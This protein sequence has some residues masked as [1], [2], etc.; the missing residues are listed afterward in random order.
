[1]KAFVTGANG[2]LGHH[3]VSKLLQLNFEVSVLIRKSSDLNELT[4]VDPEQKIKKIYGDL[5][6]VSRLKSACAGQDYIFHLAGLIAYTKKDRPALEK[7]NVEGTRNL[8]IACRGAPGLKRFIYLSSVVAVGASYSASEILNEDSAYT[9]G[10]LNL[11]YF[12]TKRKAELLVLEAVKNA[13]LPGIIFNPSTIYGAGDAKKG[14]RKTQVKVAQ[15]KFP[16]YTS[17]AVNVVSVHD[18][19]DAIVK[20]LEKAR[21]G[22]RY[23]LAGDNITIKKL[24]E[25]IAK[26]AKVSPPKYLLPRPLMIGLGNFFDLASVF[27]FKAPISL[28]NAYTATLYHWF[29]SSKA[30]KELGFTPRSAEQSVTESVAWMKLKKMI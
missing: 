23:I 14:S 28:E 18:V 19:V 11:G 29:D 10:N 9:I 1:M 16:F 26:M 22:Q 17:G 5:S 21:I 6:E 13:G 24:F 3:L 25:M 27:G 20:G 7:V 15:G 2:F 4:E 12:E 8:L 30:R